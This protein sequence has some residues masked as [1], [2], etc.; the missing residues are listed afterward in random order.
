MKSLIK[1]EHFAS[2]LKKVAVITAGEVEL[3]K[4]LAEGKSMVDIARITKRSIKTVENRF[5][6]LR[7]KTGRRK[8][9]FLVASFKEYGLI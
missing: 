8:N 7:V 5:Y 3:V 9:T 1:Q 6:K 4:A 2:E